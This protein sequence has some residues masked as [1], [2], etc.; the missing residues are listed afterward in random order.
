MNAPAVFMI[1]LAGPIDGVSIEEACGWREELAKEAPA[2]ALLFNPATAWHGVSGVTAAAAD[3]G[4][5][6]IIERCSGVVANLAGEGRAFGTIREIE[7]A[8]HCGKGVAVVV[9]RPLDSVLA[10]DVMQAE[11]PIGALQQLME[12]VI[13]G[14]QTA[15]PLE[16]MFRRMQG[17]VDE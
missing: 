2:G 3:I 11:T 8:R 15:H 10:H 13:Q 7:Y 9:D 5:R 12:W 1:Y 17:D 14:Q 16:Q 4:N 6:F